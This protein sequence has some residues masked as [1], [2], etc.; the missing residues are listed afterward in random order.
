MSDTTNIDALNTC[1]ELLAQGSTVEACLARYPELAA[2]LEP[3]LHLAMQ[4]QRLG[5]TIQPSPDAQR[6]G[7]GRITD[8]M[9]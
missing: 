9:G 3:M 1:L 6:I 8:A 7:L 2:E 4:T 5:E